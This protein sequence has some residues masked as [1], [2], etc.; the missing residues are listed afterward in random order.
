[1]KAEMINIHSGDLLNQ[2]IIFS[3]ITSKKYPGTGEMCRGAKFKSQSSLEFQ[4]L[5][6]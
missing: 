2:Q 4:T 1:M 5:G 6:D 3:E